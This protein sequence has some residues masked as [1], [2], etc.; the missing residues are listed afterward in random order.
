MILTWLVFLF[1]GIASFAS[2]VAAA[3]PS[4]QSPLRD[5]GGREPRER[6]APTGE[7]GGAAGGYPAPAR[8]THA[9]PR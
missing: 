2:V 5:G 1:L 9:P 7:P 4:F 3:V 6:A 8:P